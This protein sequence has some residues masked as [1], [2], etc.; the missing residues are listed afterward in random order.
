MELPQYEHLAQ[1]YG[2]FASWAI[3]DPYNRKNTDIIRA[4]I[5]ELHARTVMVGLNVSAPNA[6]LS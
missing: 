3:W 4:S 5:S 6:S 1:T 2:G